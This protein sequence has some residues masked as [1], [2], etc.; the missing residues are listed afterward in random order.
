MPRITQSILSEEVLDKTMNLFWEKGYFNTSVDDIITITGFNRAAIYKHFGGK[1]GLFLAMLKRYRKQVTELLTAPLR[2]PENGIEGVKSFF[3]QFAHLHANNGLSRGCLLISTAS[4]IP[5]H[6]KEVTAFINDFLSYLRKLFRTML[7]NTAIK[8][9]NKKM[10]CESIADFLVG[11]V[12]G[13][14]TLCRASAPKEVF[15]NHMA[16]IMDFLS[17]ISSKSVIKGKPKIFN[18][19]GSYS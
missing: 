15:D 11:N 6:N 1:D 5:S 17:S 2:N 3:E 19:K 8:K 18:H 12:F 16:G 4:D 10:D 7:K 9:Q 13:V 14:M